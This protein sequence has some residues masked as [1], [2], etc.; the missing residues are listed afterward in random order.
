MGYNPACMPAAQG[1][2]DHTGYAAWHAHAYVREHKLGRASTC[3]H[4][5]REDPIRQ[6]CPAP[7]E[8]RHAGRGAGAIT[9]VVSLRTRAVEQTQAASRSV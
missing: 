6:Q 2:G 9:S 3:M 1:A 7:E 5:H 8:P 4:A